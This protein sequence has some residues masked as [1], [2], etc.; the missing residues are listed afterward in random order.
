MEANHVQLFPSLEQE[1]RTHIETA[2]AAYHLLR[3]PQT[4]RIWACKESGPLRPIRVNGRLAWS[5]AEI[6]RILAGA[7]K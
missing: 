5:V 1:T 4:L 6:R 3:E 7:A 2:P